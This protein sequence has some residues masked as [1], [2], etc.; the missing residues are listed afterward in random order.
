MAFNINNFKSKG[1]IYGGA[2]PSQFRVKL[3]PPFASANSDRIQF[4]IR[5]ASLPASVIEPVEVPY[6]GRR[7]KFAGDRVYQDW[8]VQVMN[9][10]DFPVRAILERWS[11]DINAAISN[12]MNP[13]LFPRGY[14]QTAEVEQF[15]KTGEIMRAYRFNGLFPTMIEPIALDWGQ[16]NDVEMFGT[17]FSYDEWE[18]IMQGTTDAYNGILDGE[19]IG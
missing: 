17:T 8:Q 11:N 7:I 18:P 2:R 3:F 12:R 16:G 6:F 4:V 15:G 10:E 14:K 13:D 5:A 19:S 1:L 9:D